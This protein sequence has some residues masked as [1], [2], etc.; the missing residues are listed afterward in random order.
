MTA[1]APGPVGDDGELGDLLLDAISPPGDPSSADVGW[2][3]VHTIGGGELLNIVPDTGRAVPGSLGELIRKTHT[4]VKR[5][6][7]MSRIRRRLTSL[8][9]SGFREDFLVRA[10]RDEFS[11]WLQ[12]LARTEAADTRRNEMRSDLEQIASDP[13]WLAEYRR[14]A[15][16]RDSEIV[17]LT[18]EQL[19]DRL[20][21]LARTLQPMSRE[22]T[23]A[24]GLAP[25]HGPSG[26]SRSP[27][28][29]W[30]S[31]AAL[32]QLDS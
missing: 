10:I 26:P 11:T 17:Q 22:E 28:T 3:F 15:Q 21:G 32:A 5:E 12:Q 18:D 6:Q 20:M 31:G 2:F 8:I 25:A 7:F 29:F 4:L 1:F 24:R 13:Q 23:E 19:A 27:M 16:Q 14:H 30:Q 9:A